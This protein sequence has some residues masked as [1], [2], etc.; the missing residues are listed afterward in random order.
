MTK[1][2]ARAVVVLLRGWNDLEA[3]AAAI[4]AAQ[5]LT[6]VHSV[7]CRVDVQSGA[8]PLGA[9]KRVVGQRVEYEHI[10]W[11]VTQPDGTIPVLALKWTTLKSVVHACAC[12][13]SDSVDGEMSTR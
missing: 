10:V 11:L 13:P 12:R 8:A 6:D 7:L 4:A 3:D 2:P 9:D 1:Q 5:L